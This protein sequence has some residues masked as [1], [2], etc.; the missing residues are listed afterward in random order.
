MPRSSY[1]GHGGN[2]VHS[3][4]GFSSLPASWVLK[5]DVDFHRAG[6]LFKVNNA[7]CLFFKK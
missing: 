6:L 2:R 5:C 1:D 4:S 3:I 7:Y